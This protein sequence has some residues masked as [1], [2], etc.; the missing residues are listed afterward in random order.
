MIMS[1]LIFQLLKATE[2]LTFMTGK[3]WFK[4]SLKYINMAGEVRFSTWLLEMQ[5]NQS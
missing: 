1:P 2:E 3:S 5:R 4:S